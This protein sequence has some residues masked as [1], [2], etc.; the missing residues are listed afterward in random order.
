MGPKIDIF[1]KYKH[2]KTGRY[3]SPYNIIRKGD[4]V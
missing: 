1:L 4:F 3:K 2:E